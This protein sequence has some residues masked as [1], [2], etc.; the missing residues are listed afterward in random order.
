MVIRSEFVVSKRLS[1]FSRAIPSMLLLAASVTQVPPGRAGAATNARVIRAVGSTNVYADVIRQIGG[2]RVTVLGILSN[3]NSDP[4]TYESSTTDATTVERATLIVQNGLGYD[5]FVN[6]LEDASP[7]RNRIVIDAG[8]ALGYH[9]GDNPHI[10]YNPSTMP[11]IAT[12]IAS[13]LGRQDPN[14]RQA[15]AANLRAF[16]RSLQPWTALIA[17]VKKRFAGTPV[18]ITEP[19]FGY[20][21]LSMGLKILTPNSF[22]MAIM[23]GNDPAPQDIQ[24]EQDLLTRNTVKC[25]FY[26]QQAVAP[27]TAQL[28]G[29]A[30]SHHV[31]I[32]GVYETK[33]L[34]KT[35][36]QWMLAETNATLAAL[37]HGTS[38]EQLH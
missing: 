25:F 24:T 23:Q 28:L 18:A 20:A 4:H 19:V 26:N 1:R 34:N 33:P 15:F 37:A 2:A 35:Y 32:V 12:L 7:S 9:T 14:D 8:A 3:P 38:T 5:A 10:W 17:T 13:A 29:L 36:Q 6:K 16:D 27:I 11:R 22:A 21:A 30:R 31:P